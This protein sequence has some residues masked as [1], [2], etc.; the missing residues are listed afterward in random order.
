M[1]EI[2]WPFRAPGNLLANLDMNRRGSTAGWLVGL[3]GVFLVVYPACHKDKP[4]PPPPPVASAAHVPCEGGETRDPP[5]HEA[6]P[7]I[8]ALRAKDYDTAEKLFAGLLA[9]YPESASLRV[10]QGDALLGEDSTD[11]VGAALAAYAAARALDSSGCKLRDKER[12]FLAVGMADAELR[13]KHAEPAL[14]ELAEADRQW[15]D[16]AEVAYHRARAE[17]LLGKRDACFED[18]RSAFER[19]H[20]RQRVRFTR[21]HHSLD[22]LFVRAARQPE[23]ADLRKEPR[24]KALVAKAA[25]GDGGVVT[26]EDDAGPGAP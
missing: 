25:R 6:R 9:K 4:K 5:H 16:S 26:P 3:V 21:S 2:C 13:Q 1:L 18:L 8:Q 15:P 23:F 22:D 24:Y 7:A 10:W 17:C 12:Y 11:D 14:V 20:S 19:A